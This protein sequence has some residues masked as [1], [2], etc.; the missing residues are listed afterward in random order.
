MRAQ[1]ICHWQYAENQTTRQ[2]QL[3]PRAVAAGRR[4]LGDVP[5]LRPGSLKSRFEYSAS[6]LQA[7]LAA[8][9]DH[10]LLQA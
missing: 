5:R 8:L 7:Q 1:F 10:T 6:R 3:E 4:R 2:T 9:V